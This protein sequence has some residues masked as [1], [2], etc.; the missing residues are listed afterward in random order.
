MPET[1]DFP[2]PLPLPDLDAVRGLLRGLPGPDEAAA[3]ACRARDGE[4]TKPPGA[5]GR[6][7]EL[8]AWLAA[9]QGRHPPRLDRVLILV[10]VGWHG[11]ARHGVSAFPAEVTDQMVANFA[12][13]GAAINQL[14]ALAGAE[15]RVIPV[16][17][18]RPAR[19]FTREPAMSEAGCARAV[20]EGFAAVPAAGVD[21]LAIGEM[22]IANTTPAAA[23]AAALAGEDGARWAGPGTGLDA[24][25]VGRKAAVVDAGLARHRHA[26]AD[27]LGM[28]R[29]VG[30]REHA[31]M[32]GAIL[33][34]RLRR[35]PVMLDGF[36]ATVPAALLEALAPGAI[37][38]C[39]VGH[40]S[41][42]PGHR[43]LLERMGKR[44][45][46]DLGMRLGEASGA[47]LAV[48]VARAAVACH[49]GMAT[50]ASAAVSR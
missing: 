30:G 35:V 9:W 5:L 1:R 50:F 24:E 16:G 42:E 38:H 8:A 37:D 14:A 10:F 32:M 21:L 11:V 3:A 26:M 27:P 13:G 17:R 20:A 33:A 46:L 34:A 36:T 2:D 47:A 48:Q 29:H 43:R 45:L 15:L 25:G 31:A 23:L 41:A 12:A 7:E 18:G 22:G 4:L 39:Q 49:N 6:L 19:D 28:L 40:R 44:P